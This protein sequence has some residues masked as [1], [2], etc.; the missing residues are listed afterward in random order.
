MG[1]H[2]RNVE[3]AHWSDS[4]LPVIQALFPSGMDRGFFNKAFYITPLPNYTWTFFVVKSRK[5]IFPPPLSSFYLASKAHW[6]GSSLYLLTFA[7]WRGFRE[8]NTTTNQKKERRQ[9]K[10]IKL[11]SQ[12]H[13]PMQGA[14]IHHSGN[15]W[16]LPLSCC[17][18]WLQ[19]QFRHTYRASLWCSLFE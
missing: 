14:L 3:W 18:W 9:R 13:L 16:L 4:A 2:S 12:W 17:S 5:S 7:Q 1:T 10:I 6:P 15:S 11:W 8:N 19:G